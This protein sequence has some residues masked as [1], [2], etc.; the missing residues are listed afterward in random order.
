MSFDQNNKSNVTKTVDN[1][2]GKLTYSLTQ[3]VSRSCY[4]GRYFMLMS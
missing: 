2:Y 4:D 3:Q 1:P